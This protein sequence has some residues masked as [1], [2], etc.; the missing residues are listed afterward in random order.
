MA[1]RGQM[2]E[3]GTPLGKSTQGVQGYWFQRLRQWLT[4]GS[5]TLAVVPVRAYNGCSNHRERFQPLATESAL[6]CEASRGGQSWSIM[7]HSAML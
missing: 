3:W 5:S 1:V 4:G 7:L 2:I 6:E